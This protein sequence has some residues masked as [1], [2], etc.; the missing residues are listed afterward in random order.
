MKIK[1]LITLILIVVI[2]LSLTACTSVLR[3]IIFDSITKNPS[4]TVDTPSDTKAVEEKKTIDIKP[5]ETPPP[6]D[7]NASGDSS[8]TSTIDYDSTEIQPVSSDRAAREYL[9]ETVSVWLEGGT[10]FPEGTEMA[11]RTYEDFVTHIGCEASEY[12]YDPSFSARN[13]S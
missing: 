3:N 1:K 8:S 11:K 9:V 13:Y 10:V 6:S 12:R 7:S 5:E 4:D 2:S